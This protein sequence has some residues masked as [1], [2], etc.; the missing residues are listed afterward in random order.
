[1]EITMIR[2]PGKGVLLALLLSVSLLSCSEPSEGPKSAEVPEP[3]AAAAKADTGQPVRYPEFERQERVNRIVAMVTGG[4]AGAKAF[5]T[6]A[7]CHGATGFGS[8]D[9][10]IP[11]LAGQLEPVLIEKLVE[12]SSGIRHRPQMEPFSASIDE[13]DEIAALAA[14]IAALPDPEDVRHGTGQDLA[15][16]QE[17]FEKFC[18][19]CHEADGRGNGEGRIPRIAGWDA[20]SIVRTL[21]ILGA[22]YSEVH[23]TG[24]SD[25]VS[26]MTE[27][28]IDV[29]ADYVS[30]LALVAP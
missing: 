19:S 25:L 17:T 27:A 13:D 11:R 2:E 9:G 28:E 30:R 10:E 22:D 1:M 7:T 4:T 21:I 8:R 20:P 6:C 14:Y 15:L 5:K 12:I 3:S 24:M 23:E 18:V 16:G 26:M 29:V